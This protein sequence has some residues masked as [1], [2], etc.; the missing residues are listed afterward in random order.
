MT[1]KQD[2]NAIVQQN[3]PAQIVFICNAAFTGANVGHRIAGILTLNDV[4]LRWN[5]ATSKWRC[6]SVA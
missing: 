5:V 1:T 4:T 6:M 2:I 3:A